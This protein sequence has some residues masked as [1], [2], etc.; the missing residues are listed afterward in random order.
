MLYDALV[1]T[2]LLEETPDTTL[3]IYVGKRAN[4]H[5]F[6][7]EEINQMLVALAHQH[8]HVVRLKGGDAFVFGRGQEELDFARKLGVPVEVVPGISSCI[9]V[10]ELQQVPVTARGVSESFWVITGTTRTG[11]L[12][13]DIELAAQ[14]TATVIILMGIRKLEEIRQLFIK[15][16][17]FDT[18]AMV[19]QNGSRSNERKVI[20]TIDSIVEQVREAKIGTPGIIVIGDV[21]RLHPEFVAQAVEEQFT[22]QRKAA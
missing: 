18:P 5:S 11:Q 16:G 3:K 21:V 12:S 17:R 4:K 9:S 14:S 20:G 13:R 10:P 2:E 22:L 8:G 15:E 7:Q 6:R 19:V 1:N